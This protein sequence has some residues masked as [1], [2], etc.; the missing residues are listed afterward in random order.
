MGG[1]F[2]NIDAA[3][4]L[5]AL[6][7]AEGNAGYTG[8][9]APGVDAEYHPAGIVIA[10]I[11]PVK[12]FRDLHDAGVILERIQQCNALRQLTLE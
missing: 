3:E 11:L 9:V 2:R 10:V 5:K 4:F 7:I 8:A 1:E 12:F 6:G